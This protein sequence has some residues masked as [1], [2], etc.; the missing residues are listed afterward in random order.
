M[1]CDKPREVLLNVLGF[2]PCNYVS[3][4]CSLCFVCCVLFGGI[5]C[6]WRKL[7]CVLSSLLG[8]S[9]LPDVLMSRGFA[10]F[11][12]YCVFGVNMLWSS[13]AVFC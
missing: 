5:N 8:L 10:C 2:A 7:A 12:L 3:Q 9:I 11:C 1:L 6:F 13:R 4:L